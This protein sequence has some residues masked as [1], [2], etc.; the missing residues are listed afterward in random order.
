MEV[1]GK[2]GRVDR[3]SGLE[4]ENE[5][6]LGHFKEAIHRSDDSEEA[7]S[8]V[9]AE[10]SCLRSM[11]LE[12]Q[13]TTMWNSLALVYMLSDNVSDAEEAIER[14]LDIDT[15]NAWTWSI[16]G[17]LLKHMGRLVDAERA[18]RMVLELDPNDTHAL[19]Q[20]VTI[21]TLRDAYPEVL[22]MLQR[23]IP[24][25]PNDQELWDAYSAC[26]RIIRY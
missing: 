1:I 15:S 9:S 21:Y 5:N 14:S 23:L 24:L 25:T 16:W 2:A 17:D 7:K 12:P 26:L 11:M 20:S 18:F 3:L 8:V 13:N 19:H 22:D 4:I 6:I 10:Y